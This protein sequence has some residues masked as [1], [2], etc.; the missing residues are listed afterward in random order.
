[1]TR[2][3][4]S[5]PNF[6]KRVRES[7]ARQKLMTTIGARLT[8]VLPAEVVIEIPFRDDLTQQHGFMHAGIVTAIVDTACGYAA[9]S[10]MPAD[11]DVLSVEFK[12]N[13]LS[14]AAGE[15]MI[16]RGRVIRAGRTLTV[17][18]GDVV[19]VS[20]GREERIASMLATMIT[21]RGS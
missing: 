12:I 3:H 1:M 19:A 20:H 2:P 6:E 16:A 9:L 18:E 10:L 17:C 14:P 5:D 4:P 21:R 13:L 11:A 7:F 8:V 15:R